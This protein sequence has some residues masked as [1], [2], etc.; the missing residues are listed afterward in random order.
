MMLPRHHLAGYEGK[1]ARDRHSEQER[2][3]KDGEQLAVTG[4]V[5]KKALA[6]LYIIGK[7]LPPNNVQSL[8]LNGFIYN[9]N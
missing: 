9:A 4:W 5:D 3:N 8:F 7:E 6:F 2:Q 1:Q